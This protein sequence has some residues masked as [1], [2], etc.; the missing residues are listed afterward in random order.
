MLSNYRQSGIVVILAWP[1]AAFACR[2]NSRY[3][4]S[5]PVSGHGTSGLTNEPR[6]FAT[7]R[8]SLIAS[9]TNSDNRDE[10]ARTALAEL[11]RIYWRP[12]FSF[13]CRRG[14]PPEDAQDLTQ[15]FFV[16]IL[17]GDW[18]DRADESR[19]RFR[20]YLLKSLE[21]FLSNERGKSHARK[22]GGGIEF[23]SW[24]D[25]TAEA[26]S[27]VFMPAQALHSM[28]ADKL[29]DLRWAATVVEYALQRLAEE[30][31][32]KGRR[33]LFDTLRPYLCEERRDTSYQE[34]AA[35]LGV[36]ESVIRKQL[37]NLRQRY[38][39]LLRAHVAQ[40]VADPN[41]VDAEIRY[42][43][44]TLSAAEV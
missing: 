34:L 15:G 29:F 38:R 20:S 23:V 22:R 10:E 4:E 6:V 9:A 1:D 16:K 26:H 31:E 24:D 30:C 28:P 21:H 32:A 25:W 11:C 18:L 42:L 17:E 12:V 37:H 44:A 7:T 27:Q 39:S 35:T 40:T 43:C 2:S 8:W 13:V 3:T 14:Y 36:T 19:G 33:R 5:H 41:E